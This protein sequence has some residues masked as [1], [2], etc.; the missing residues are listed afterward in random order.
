M[1]TPMPMPTPIP[2]GGAPMPAYGGG[3]GPAPAPIPGGG[4]GGAL[5]GGP[6]ACPYPPAPIPIPIGPAGRPPIPGV[7]VCAG[8]LFSPATLTRIRLPSTEA[9]FIP[10]TALCA[11]SWSANFTNPNPRGVPS[12]CRTTCADSIA[13]WASKMARR[14]PSSTRSGSDPTYILRGSTSRSR[15]AD[16]SPGR[17]AGAA[18]GAP[19][20]GTLSTPSSERNDRYSEDIFSAAAAPSAPLPFRGQSNVGWPPSPQILHVTSAT[21]AR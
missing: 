17:D 21:S 7:P 5:I 6:G 16:P 3:G 8:A 10:A 1:P 11:A 18:G 2:G 15:P 14:A 12:G 20:P 9:P 13:P 4:G 19:T